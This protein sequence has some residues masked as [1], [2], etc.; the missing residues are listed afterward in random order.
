M[1]RNERQG[2]TLGVPA[3]FPS[4]YV[5]DMSCTSTGGFAVASQTVIRGDFFYSLLS[6]S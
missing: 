4:P 1:L 3:G 2:K 6:Y 5:A